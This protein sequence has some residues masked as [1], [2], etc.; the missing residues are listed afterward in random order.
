MSKI[1]EKTVN[2]LQAYVSRN[3]LRGEFLLHEFTLEIG[4]A[5][6]KEDE[7][8]IILRKL[9]TLEQDM[10][11]CTKTDR[12]EECLLQAM[13]LEMMGHPTPFAYVHAVKLLQQG[14]LSQKLIGYLATSVFLDPSH[15]L[16]VLLINSIQRDLASKVSLAVVMALEII[17]KLIHGE[18]AYAVQP[19]VL[20]KTKHYSS[21]VRQAALLALQHCHS[22]CGSCQLPLTV[23]PVLEAGLA[24]S[25]VNVVASAALCIQECARQQSSGVGHLCSPL[26]EVL[27]Q[28]R[29]KKVHSDYEFGGI[30][31][32]WLQLTILSALG[33]MTHNTEQ[34]KDVLS[35][36]KEILESRVVNQTICYAILWESLHTM[37]KVT[38]HGSPLE[39]SAVACIAKMLNSNCTDLNYSGV[40]VLERV[41]AKCCPSEAVTCQ[42]VIIECLHHP[43]ESVRIKTLNLLVT[44]ANANNVAAIVN[45]ILKYA[46]TSVDA[47]VRTFVCGKIIHLLKLYS[48]HIVWFATTFVNLLFL[49]PDQVSEATALEFVNIFSK[50]GTVLPH[51]LPV[52]LKADV[53]L[54]GRSAPL[55]MLLAWAFGEVKPGGEPTCSFEE[56]L[57][58][59]M[60]LLE[61]CQGQ[62][63]LCLCVL[64]SLCALLSNWKQ[65]LHDDKGILAHLANN[66]ASP[67]VKQRSQELVNW[68]KLLHTHKDGLEAGDHREEEA[69]VKIDTTLSFLDGFVCK[70][71]EAGAMP[72]KPRAYPQVTFEDVMVGSAATSRSDARGSS[73]AGSGSDVG[74]FST[75]FHSLASDAALSESTTKT[76]LWSTQGRIKNRIAEHQ[77]SKLEDDSVSSSKQEDVELMKAIFSAAPVVEEPVAAPALTSSTEVANA[78]PLTSSEERKPAVSKRA[79]L[80]GIGLKHNS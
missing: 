62:I 61:A 15:E 63:H 22:Q 1:V 80:W 67:L 12:L 17:P 74:A 10:K 48:S 77:M 5:P 30:S 33:H 51:I 54:S 4:A 28:L 49:A 57:H 55:V 70:A 16:V 73:V 25:E 44:M 71:L 24:D 66:S 43:D 79:E 31:A 40:D 68:N 78:E 65:P 26:L 21:A 46:S 39:K 36:I 11:D 9:S 23:L 29:L 47:A 60:S 2:S 59:L 13:F 3:I 50:D 27:S 75:D 14:Q 69:S 53:D 56:A 42:E 8:A 58:K 32:P 41:L 19:L 35:A 76:G 34:M 38:P 20:E 18:F 72:Y 7:T 64:T 6:S 52:L 37:S 45:R